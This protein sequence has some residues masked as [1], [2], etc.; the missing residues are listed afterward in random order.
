MDTLRGTASADPDET[1]K[2]AAKEPRSRPASPMHNAA[3]RG[4]SMSQAS[5]D[6]RQALPDCSRAHLR[7]VPSST[8]TPAHAMRT[9]SL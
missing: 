5:T 3:S 7:T 9:G 8:V 2:L 1:A 6:Q 4:W